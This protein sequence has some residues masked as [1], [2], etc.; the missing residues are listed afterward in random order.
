MTVMPEEVEITWPWALV[1][2]IEFGMLRLRLEV[3]A[4]PKEANPETDRSEVEALV[5]KRLF[6]VKTDDEAF[7]KVA[8]PVNHD[9]PETDK[10]DEDAL[11]SHEVPEFENRVVEAFPKLFCPVNVLLLAR[12]VEEAAKKLVVATTWP[13]ALVERIAL[14]M[15]R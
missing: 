12:R 4:V 7:P 15:L 3:D 8:S 10:S 11:V 2:R 1:E 6:A 9:C 5:E 14:G 13:L